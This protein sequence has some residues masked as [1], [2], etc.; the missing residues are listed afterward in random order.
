MKLQNGSR[1]FQPSGRRRCTRVAECPE[2]RQGPF[3]FEAEIES[4]R[5]SDLHHG[6]KL[7][8]DACVF[9]KTPKEKKKRNQEKQDFAFFRAWTI[10]VVSQYRK[11]SPQAMIVV[12]N[13]NN[14]AGETCGRRKDCIGAKRSKNVA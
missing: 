3:E 9:R 8:P 6:H 5:P 14:S 10:F 4:V 12:I 1:A 7:G 2:D 13:W 11:A